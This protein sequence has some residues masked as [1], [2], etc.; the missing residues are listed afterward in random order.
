MAMNKSQRIHLIHKISPSFGPSSFEKLIRNLFV[1]TFISFVYIWDISGWLKQKWS[2]SSKNGMIFDMPFRFYTHTTPYTHRYSSDIPKLDIVRWCYD[3][4]CCMVFQKR[5]LSS[6]TKH[7]WA[8]PKEQKVLLFDLI[9]W[10][11]VT[12]SSVCPKNNT[13]FTIVA[14]VVVIVIFVIITHTHQS[15]MLRAWMNA[16][17]WFETNTT[18]TIPAKPIK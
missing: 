11:F 14:V 1:H 15:Y 5:L 4:F 7:I 2:Q 10:V 9:K 3:Y 13:L 16:V 17:N 12:S 18:D 8:L 6:S